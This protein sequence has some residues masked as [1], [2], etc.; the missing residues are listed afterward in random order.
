M[1]GRE[2]EQPTKGAISEVSSLG[3]MVRVFLVAAREET[4]RNRARRED[5]RHKQREIEARERQRDK[6]R[7]KTRALLT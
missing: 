6:M 2:G 4:E 5:G 3:P 1:R 7:S